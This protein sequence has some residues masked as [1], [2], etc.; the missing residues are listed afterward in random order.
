[1]MYARALRD[2]RQFPAA[3]TQFYAAAKLKPAESK[4]W[5]QLGGMLFMMERFRAIARRP[6]TRPTNWA[7]TLPE[8]G[9]FVPSS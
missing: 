8:T 1:M 5:D 6:T 3:A 9:S 4:T 7:T 2:R